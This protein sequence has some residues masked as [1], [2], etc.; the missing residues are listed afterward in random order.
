M[1]RDVQTLIAFSAL[2]EEEVIADRKSRPSLL[3]EIL[4][5]KPTPKLDAAIEATE[6]KAQLLPISESDVPKWRI[7]SVRNYLPK[8]AEVQ[9]CTC[10]KLGRFVCEPTD[11]RFI[12]D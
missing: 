1:K 7:D 5:Y 6:A 8:G 12:V 11:K 3:D 9:Q 4:D 2:A 10:G